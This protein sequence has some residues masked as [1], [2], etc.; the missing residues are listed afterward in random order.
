MVVIFP[1]EGPEFG[2]DCVDTI[3]CRLNKKKRE[4][5]NECNIS[6]GEMVGKLTHADEMTPGKDGECIHRKAL[7]WNHSCR[8]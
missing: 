6:N 7:L 3:Q 1:P 4:K 2:L 5:C 8:K